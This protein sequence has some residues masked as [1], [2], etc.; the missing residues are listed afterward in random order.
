MRLLT[1]LLAVIAACTALL[2][3]VGLWIDAPRH[4]MQSTG[5]TA[6]TILGIDDASAPAHSSASGV[7]DLGVAAGGEG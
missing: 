7:V 3:G 5:L 6:A 2:V 1:T 4:E